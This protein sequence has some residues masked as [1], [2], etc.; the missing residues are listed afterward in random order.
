VRLPN[1]GHLLAKSD[2]AIWDRLESWLPPLVS[3]P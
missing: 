3:A 2:V 1:D